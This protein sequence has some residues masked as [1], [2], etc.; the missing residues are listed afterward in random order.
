MYFYTF[1]KLYLIFVKFNL[2]FLFYFENQTEVEIFLEMTLL[3]MFFKIL[4]DCKALKYIKTIKKREFFL[5][6]SVK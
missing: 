3:K 4:F 1:E 2:Y 6:I 5:L